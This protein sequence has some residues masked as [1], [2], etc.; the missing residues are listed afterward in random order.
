MFWWQKSH[1][2]FIACDTAA[3]LLLQRKIVLL[4]GLY[5]DFQDVVLLVGIP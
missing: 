1:T 2:L 3:G 5:R 4:A